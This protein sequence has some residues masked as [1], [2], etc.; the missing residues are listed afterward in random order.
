[1]SL[2][3][4]LGDT[5][6]GAKSGS[7]HFSRYFNKFFDNVFYP[8]LK[9]HNIKEVIQFGDLFDSR[10]TL[11]L[12]A[13]HASKNSWFSPL[14]ENNIKMH[15]LV[16]NHDS[17]HKNSIHINSP[18]LFV[19][20]AYPDN[21]K[22]YS[23]PTVLNIYNQN[24]LMVPWICDENREDVYNFLKKNNSTGN[25]CCGHFEID[26]FSM[27]RGIQ[28]D[29]GLPKTLFENFQRTF[30]GHYHTQSYDSYYRIQYIGT[31]YELTF[32]D[33]DDPR[34]F[35]VFDTDTG[36]VTFIQNPY[37]MFSRIVYN[38]GWDGDINSLTDKLVKIVVESKSDL[39]EFDRFVD[40]VKL[41]NAYDVKLLE[42]VQYVQ[43]ENGQELVVQDSLTIIDNYIDS[44]TTSVDKTKLKEY[45]R[46][47]YAE[48]ISL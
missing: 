13:F 10:T 6:L 38:N 18:E 45:M 32:A 15:V 20:D 36:E 42:S 26:G 47:L 8:Y 31:P 14:V 25:I 29:G 3:A 9:E 17:Y 1:M 33:V 12:K 22:V 39:Y 2:V 46:G 43:T 30:S 23:N 37:T 34:G 5:H 35:H 19:A 41:A 4:L 7:G 16:G 11:S 27:M 21:V 28:S 40:S 48:A 44:L 24:F